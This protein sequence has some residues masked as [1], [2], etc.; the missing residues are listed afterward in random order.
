MGSGL[1]L[2]ILLP[3]LSGKGLHRGR[4][5]KP[6]L[7]ASP[8]FLQTASSSG[9]ALRCR[10]SS[11]SWPRAFLPAW[12]AGRSGNSSPGFP[13]P[14]PAWRRWRFPRKYCPSWQKRCWSPSC[15]FRRPLPADSRESRPED[16]PLDPA[17]APPPRSVPPPHL[18]PEGFPEKCLPAS[19]KPQMALT[20]PESAQPSP[21]A[22]I[23]LFPPRETSPRHRRLPGSGVPSASSGCSRKEWSYRRSPSHAPPRLR[24]PDRDG[25]SSTAPECEIPASLSAPG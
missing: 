23:A 25:R 1:L 13:S 9:S 3:W 18:R 20:A 19:R 5:R 12:P 8:R 7:P 11:E 21:G 16:P 17:N 6:E 22:S 14:A 24:P 2:P 10:Y 15:R 4:P